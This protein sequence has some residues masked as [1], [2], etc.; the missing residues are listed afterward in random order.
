MFVIVDAGEESILDL[1]EA[2]FEQDPASA[3]GLGGAV[4]E[5]RVRTKRYLEDFPFRI[6]WW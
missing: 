5:M 1:K 4:P 3:S 6:I 2:V